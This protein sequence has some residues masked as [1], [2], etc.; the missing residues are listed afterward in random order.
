MPAEIRH[1]RYSLV[2]G[3]RGY[4][5]MV[6]YECDTDFV[7]VGRHELICDV[8]ER[9]SGPPPRC[10]RT[11]IPAEKENVRSLG[12]GATVMRLAA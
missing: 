5:S 4:L 12:D 2:N 11:Y 3:T 1:G 10:E 7:M 8:D 9:W 6:V